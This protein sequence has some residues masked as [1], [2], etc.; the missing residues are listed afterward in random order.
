MRLH[1]CLLVACVTLSH[2]CDSRETSQPVAKPIPPQAPAAAEPPRV[3]VAADQPSAR[4]FEILS[5]APETISRFVLVVPPDTAGV[6]IRYAAR[7]TAD[8]PGMVATVEADGDLLLW[9]AQGTEGTSGKPELVTRV[10][11]PGKNA[12]RAALIEVANRTGATRMDIIIDREQPTRVLAELLA[13]VRARDDGRPLFPDVRVIAGVPT[14]VTT[15]TMRIMTEDL[16]DQIEAN[17]MPLRKCFEQALKRDGP[18]GMIALE[19]T[20][21]LGKSGRV[22]AV[23]ITGEGSP[24]LLECLQAAIRAWILVADAGTY[25]FRLEMTTQ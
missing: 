7:A 5:R 18:T 11:E 2:A 14:P 21:T 1:R 24:P 4:V 3:E 12:L 23:R 19:I 8:G 25:K 22:V 17:S 15:M 20:V 10:D 16:H 13:T 9:S 6:P